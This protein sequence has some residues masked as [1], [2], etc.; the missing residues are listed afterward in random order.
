MAGHGQTLS[1][2]HV[3]LDDEF[4]RGPRVDLPPLIIAAAVI[5]VMLALTIWVIR[6]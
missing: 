2:D 1:L 6:G 5:L 4:S 3:W